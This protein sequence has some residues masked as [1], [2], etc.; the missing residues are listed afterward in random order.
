MPAPSPTPP[1]CRPSLLSLAITGILLAPGA[2][3]ATITVG[4]TADDGTGCTLR[5]AITSINDASA[6]DGCTNGGGGFGTDDTI[7]F[8]SAV[9]G[10]ITLAG[11][12]L[13]ITQSVSIDGPGADALAVDGGQQ[14]RI[15]NIGAG[16]TVAIDGLTI[17]NGSTADDGGG[18]YVDGATLTISNSTVSGNFAD[19][20][21]GG[22]SAD[23]A[24]LTVTN[25]TVTGN[26]TG[27]DDGG[28][29]FAG[30]GTLM[31]VSDSTISGNSAADDGGGIRVSVSQLMLTNSAVTGNYAAD[32][33][34]GIR[35]V[36]SQLTLTNSTV[37][38]NSA[39]DDGGGIR[40][41]ST[42]TVTITNCTI[43]GNSA[44]GDDGGGLRIDDVSTLKLTNSTV[45]SNS[46]ASDGGGIFVSSPSIGSSSSMTLTNS[47]IANSPGGGDCRAVDADVTGSYNLIGDSGD[48]ACGLSNGVDSNIIGTDPDLG[49]LADNGCET[50]AGNPNGPAASYGCVQTH[51]LLTVSPGIDTADTA[52]AP[53][54]DQ[55]G[56]S[57]PQGPAADIGAYEAAVAAPIPTLSVWG[58]LA[59][60]GL[61]GLF[62]ARRQRRRR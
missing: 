19:D 52:A 16:T 55:R 8:D 54:T 24:T 22:I 34:G 49:P 31:T 38:G 15:F 18:I 33:G 53:D 36:D 60:A 61:L 50:L 48:D 28:G 39:E 4:S 11:N 47:I 2:H 57:R 10:T 29:L 17:Q 9:T 41:S 20:D 26:S 5:E 58:L 42:S 62:G 6:A 7:V 3:A 12:E 23:G 14:S 51:A 44:I 30:S 27:G 43:S 40:A 56:V 21:G 35:V 25:S 32:D 1:K 13:G 45:A 37:A 46:A 59:S